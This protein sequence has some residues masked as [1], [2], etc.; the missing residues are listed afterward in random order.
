MKLDP[1]PE[2][3]QFEHDINLNSKVD[4]RID[5]EFDGD[6][7]I[8]YINYSLSNNA[9]G[10]RTDCSA[11]IANHDNDSQMDFLLICE[12]PVDDD[13]ITEINFPNNLITGA[14]LNG[15]EIRNF[16]ERYEIRADNTPPSQPSILNPDQ[17]LYTSYTPPLE[18]SVSFQFDNLSSN[19]EYFIQHQDGTELTVESDY[20]VV[21]S[22]TS[23]N[24]SVILNNLTSDDEFIDFRIRT[25][26]VVGNQSENSWS[27]QVSNAPPPSQIVASSFWSQ[28]PDLNLSGNYSAGFSTLNNNVSFS[29][30]GHIFS[31]ADFKILN[32]QS[33]IVDLPGCIVTVILHHIQINCEHYSGQNTI[34]GELTIKFNSGLF[35]NIGDGS[36]INEELPFSLRIIADLPSMTRIS[37][38]D[39]QAYG[40]G[41]FNTP[42]LRFYLPALSGGLRYHVQ[43]FADS[44]K[45]SN[46]DS[47]DSMFNVFSPE[48]LGNFDSNELIRLTAN[49]YH[50]RTRNISTNEPMPIFI[51]VRKVPTEATV[52]DYVN[53]VYTCISTPLILDFSPKLNIILRQIDTLLSGELRFIYQASLSGIN[54][55]SHRYY[56]PDNHE[57]RRIQNQN[58]W[59]TFIRGQTE[60]TIQRNYDDLGLTG[61]FW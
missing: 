5:P 47:S 46:D 53:Y 41:I 10:G 42:E 56:D 24:A 13:F 34:N 20:Q 8:Q 58:F 14:T 12:S 17:I 36:I 32:D 9:P 30:D 6:T 19:V 31:Q 54:H 2:G 59:N 45:C 4:A 16:E 52:L 61:Q 1:V 35:K 60:D 7:I 43:S 18:N 11:Q 55:D 21:T 15:V 29:E 37:D 33:V 57:W 49:R 50:L 44:D 3:N 27:L 38:S 22:F 26:D 25:T 40:D 51:Q 48:S 23:G 28:N 39:Y